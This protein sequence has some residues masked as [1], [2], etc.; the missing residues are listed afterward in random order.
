MTNSADIIHHGG[1]QCGAV[2]FI[3]RGAPILVANCHC[4][5]CRKATGAAFTTFV[6]F[7]R[8]HVTFIP[9]PSTFYPSPTVERLFCSACGTPIGY[10]GDGS[11]DEINLYLG[12]FKKPENFEPTEECNQ[13]SA[14]WKNLK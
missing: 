13:E 8:D 4:H 5:D 2:T 12:A 14:L 7:Q 9:E 3:A 10:R 1:C 11:I 6:D